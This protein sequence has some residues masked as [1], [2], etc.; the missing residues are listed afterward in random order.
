MPR[1]LLEALAEYLYAEIRYTKH[2]PEVYSIDRK[3]AYLEHTVALLHAV[4][5]LLEEGE[6]SHA[7]AASPHCACAC[8][9]PNVG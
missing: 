1:P 5:A 7:P 3:V 8:H 2:V 9:T 4:V 6:S